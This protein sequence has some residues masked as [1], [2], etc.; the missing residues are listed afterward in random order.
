MPKVITGTYVVTAFSMANDE[1]TLTCQRS[2]QEPRHRSEYASR[3]KV[4]TT[5]QEIAQQLR[6]MSLQGKPHNH[7]VMTVTV[8][9]DNDAAKL[10]VALQQTYPIKRPHH[11]VIKLTSGTV[12]ESKSGKPTKYAIA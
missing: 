4:Q 3:V 12:R 8:S 7:I 11:P 1:V 10:K 9:G 5:N 6:L 2:S